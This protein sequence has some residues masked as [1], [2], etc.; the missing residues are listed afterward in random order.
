MDGK[1]W[2]R[3]YLQQPHWQQVRHDKLR[4]HPRC[5]ACGL[6]DAAEIHHLHYRSIWAERM[7]DLQSLCWHCHRAAHGRKPPKMTDV[8]AALN[9]LMVEGDLP[10]WSPI[11]L[12]SPE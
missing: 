6:V 9:Y 8:R 4:F 3:W 12:W 11:K 7:S 5:Q 2:Y 10:P 1:T